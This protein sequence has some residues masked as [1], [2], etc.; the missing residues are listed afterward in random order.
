MAVTFEKYD[1]AK[2]GA[3]SE[4]GRRCADP[5]L[6][7]LAEAARAH[8]VFM[9][10]GDYANAAAASSAIRGRLIALTTDGER[11][12]IRTTADKG[13]IVIRVFPCE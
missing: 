4:R 1:P 9:P 6:A 12:S 5:A 11:I 8:E 3:F 7:A 13:G 10:I 2:H